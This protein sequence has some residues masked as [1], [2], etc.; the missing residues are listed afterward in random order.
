MIK[1]SGDSQVARPGQAF[2]EPFVVLAT[3]EYGK[4]APGTIVRF[5]PFAAECTDHEVE[6]DPSGYASVRCSAGQIP[7]G[8]GI[9]LQ[10]ALAAQV[11]G[12]TREAGSTTFNFAVAFAAATV[13]IERVSG[14]DQIATPGSTIPLVFRLTTGFGTAEFGVQVRQVSGP[15]A[16]VS[17]NFLTTRPLINN[18][19]NVTLGSQVG[20]VVIELRVIAPNHPIARFHIL[21]RSN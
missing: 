7:Q 13:G 14:D 16:F 3:D 21:A 1:V 11:P 17:P 4:S 12:R 15:S 8:A 19:V 18:R 9:S 5:T 6:T 10:G 2:P 20:D